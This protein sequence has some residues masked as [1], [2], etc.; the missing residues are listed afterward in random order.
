MHIIAWISATAVSF[1]LYRPGHAILMDFVCRYPHFTFFIL[2]FFPHLNAVFQG[3]VIGRNEISDVLR[4]VVNGIPAGLGWV[5]RFSSYL[6]FT[7][8]HF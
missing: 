5:V 1:P 4:S 8:S 2:I 7:K 3:G 6:I